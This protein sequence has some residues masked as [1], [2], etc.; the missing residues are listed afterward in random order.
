[1]KLKL[2][3]EGEIGIEIEI[4][5]RLQLCKELAQESVDSLCTE[6]SHGT[7]ICILKTKS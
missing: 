5:Y 3:I 2:K 4:D 1:M 6:L 7:A